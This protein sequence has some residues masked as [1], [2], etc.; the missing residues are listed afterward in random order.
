M[1]SNADRIPVAIIDADAAMRSGLQYVFDVAP[2]GLVRAAG[3]P[4][5]IVPSDA[6]IIAVIDPA[7]RGSPDYALL[8]DARRRLTRA[9]FIVQ[10][11]AFDLRL[12]GCALEAGA[13]AYLLKGRPSGEAAPEVAEFIW[14]TGGVYWDESIR[15][16]FQSQPGAF[17]LTPTVHVGRPLS[18]KERDVLSLIAQGLADK[19]I[20]VRMRIKATTV[21]THVHRLLRKLGARNRSHAVHFATLYGLIEPSPP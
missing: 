17:R 8:R 11:L 21:D 16:F 14:R 6:P 15:A 5:A 1:D 7:P 10:T 12:L 19:E 13:G 3:H 9:H 4:S 20:E 18:P 2:L